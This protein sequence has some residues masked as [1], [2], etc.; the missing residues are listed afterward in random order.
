MFQPSSI[1]LSKQLSLAADSVQSLA[2]HRHMDLIKESIRLSRA[3][4][5][6]DVS[7]SVVQTCHRVVLR[8]LSHYDRTIRS[9]GYKE[10]LGVVKESLRI[11]HVTHPL[12]TVCQG[13]LFLLDTSV[14]YQICC[15]GLYDE[16]REVH[17]ILREGKA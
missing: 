6:S 1:T 17:I 9:E 8:L 13:I 14:M 4:C 10:C 2:Y 12:S 3:A 5:S 15:Y 16:D 11:S 7:S